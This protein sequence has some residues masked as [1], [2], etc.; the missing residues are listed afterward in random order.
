MIEKNGCAAV[1]LGGGGLGG[2]GLEE[3]AAVWEAGGRRWAGRQRW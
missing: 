1:R 3:S 2:C